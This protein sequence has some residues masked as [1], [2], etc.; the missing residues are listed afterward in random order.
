V[1]RVVSALLLV[2]TPA[3]AELLSSF[4][5]GAQVAPVRWEGPGAVDPQEIRLT[6]TSY[7]VSLPI[8]LTLTQSVAKPRAFGFVVGV[9]PTF[10]GPKIGQSTTFGHFMLEALGRVAF[11]PRTSWGLQ[12]GAGVAVEWP[13][14][15]GDNA[16]LSNDNVDPFTRLQGGIAAVSL[17][18]FG[19]AHDL[20]F[21]LRAAV[22]TSEHMS[23]VPVMLCASYEW[24]RDRR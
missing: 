15:G 19:A 22:L 20:T 23:S 12:V 4:G 13:M 6:G 1:L 17:T 3:R 2:A 8:R 9:T 24:G 10:G 7:G 11:R 5:I 14:G 18:R 21:D 16:V